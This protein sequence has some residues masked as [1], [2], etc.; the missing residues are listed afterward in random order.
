MSKERKI[1]KLTKYYPLFSL[2]FIKSIINTTPINS[3]KIINAKK[4]TSNEKIS[5]DSLGL[6]KA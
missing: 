4:G 2:A 3:L 1:L 5:Y 6:I